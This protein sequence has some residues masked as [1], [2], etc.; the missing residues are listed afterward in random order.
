MAHADQHENEK[1]LLI[2]YQFEMIFR[3]SISSEEI[4]ALTNLPY[5][6][7]AIRMRVGAKNLIQYQNRCFSAAASKKKFIFIHLRGKPRHSRRGG[8]AR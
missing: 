2:E 4:R 5:P 7:R 3:Y 8:M 1:N 6:L